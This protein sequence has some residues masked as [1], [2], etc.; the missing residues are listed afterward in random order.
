MADPIEDPIPAIGHHAPV[1][2]TGMVPRTVIELRDIH[3]TLGDRKVLD[4]VS[5]SIFKGETMCIM[6]QSGQGKSVTL[7]H[8]VGLMR[9]DSGKVLV[10]GIDITGSHNGELAEARKKIGFL[11]QN[12]ALLNSL[13]L[14]ENVALPLREHEHLTEAEIQQ[15]VEEKLTL[16]G[17][18]EHV[19][20]LPGVLSGGMKKRAGLA[21]AIVRDPEI[22]L[23][24]KPT[25]G[26][27]PIIS[28]TINELILDMQKKLGVTSI[29][30]THDMSSAFKVSNRMAMLYRGKILKLG[31]PGEFRKTDDPLVKQF[32]FGESEGP[33][34]KDVH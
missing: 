6:G 28:A 4:G 24:D 32:I 2:L 9:P 33:L 31:S 34:T 16:V 13:T 15:R 8:I 1:S 10:A 29:I 5:L 26:L 21:R 20:K 30:V 7:K 19:Q 3:K 11:F 25:A 14:F 27:D 17:L 12:A 23:Y 22:L 18:A